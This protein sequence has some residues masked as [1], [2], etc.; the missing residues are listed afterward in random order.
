[1]SRN[2]PPLQQKII[3]T[4]YELFYQNGYTG[5]GL[6][7]ILDAGGLTKGAIYHHFASKKEI[8]LSVI[9]EIIRGFV[10]ERFLHQMRETDDPIA[11]IRENL[12][13]LAGKRKLDEIKKG[14]PLNNLAQEMS[15]SDPEFRK[16]LN[17][18][19]VEWIDVYQNAILRG[20]R[21]GNVKKSVDAHA[22]ASFIVASI[23][24]MI[25]LGK[26]FQKKESVIETFSFFFATL[27]LYR[28]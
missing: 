27:E 19:F 6:S 16:K 14:C 7:D 21:A 4:A 23:E 24:G 12:L 17:L 26:N 20:Q 8:G 15:Y 25:G 28:P 3:N 11:Q 2:Q 22:M 5:T 1:M 18:L 10:E 9:D 13:M